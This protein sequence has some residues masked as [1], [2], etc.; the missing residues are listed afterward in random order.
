MSL[1][2]RSSVSSLSDAR[3]MLNT[4]EK[5]IY[6]HR[7]SHI[8]SLIQGSQQFPETLT[9]EQSCT[10]ESW[11][12]SCGWTGASP[13]GC[14]SHVR[15]FSEETFESFNESFLCVHS[16]LLR[17]SQPYYL[18]CNSLMQQEDKSDSSVVPVVG[19]RISPFKGPCTK[20]P[21]LW[22]C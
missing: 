9:G 6:L 7:H 18:S 15:Y 2:P 11:S 4:M 21:T 20:P 22:K 8:C 10:L 16:T 14:S 17:I 13:T 12:S 1:S 5:A 3:M 19:R